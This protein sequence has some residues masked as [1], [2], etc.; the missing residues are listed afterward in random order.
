MTAGKVCRS[1]AFLSGQDKSSCTSGAGTLARP[2]HT[3]R[4]GLGDHRRATFDRLDDESPARIPLL[5][6]DPEP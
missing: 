3:S 1:G 5:Q 4:M 6:E 2:P